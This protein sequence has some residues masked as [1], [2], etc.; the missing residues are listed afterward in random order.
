MVVV[1][2]PK[3]SYADI[4]CPRGTYD[5]KDV[6]EVRKTLFDAAVVLGRL[7]SI[8]NLLI[9]DFFSCNHRRAFRAEFEALIE[10]FDNIG[11]EAN[12]STRTRYYLSKLINAQ[13]L[14]FKGALVFDP[15]FDRIFDQEEGCTQIS[16][17]H[18]TTSSETILPAIARLT[19]CAASPTRAYRP[20]RPWLFR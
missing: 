5:R 17:A 6:L 19:A 18:A 7:N 3:Y 2:T 20:R 8:A 15:S 10:L 12:V 9:P 13:F 14:G 4:E 16:R 1:F 11:D